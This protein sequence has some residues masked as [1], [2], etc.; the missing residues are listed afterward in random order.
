MAQQLSTQS[1]EAKIIL[2]SM[3]LISYSIKTYKTALNHLKKFMTI[4]YDQDE[5]KLFVDIKNEEKDLSVSQ[6]FC[7]LSR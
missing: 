2:D 5:T 6:R 4:R 3:Y 1:T 7:N